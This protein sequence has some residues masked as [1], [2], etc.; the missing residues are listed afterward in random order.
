M[1]TFFDILIFHKNLKLNRSLTSSYK[2]IIK[3]NQIPCNE[4]KQITRFSKRI[5]PAHPMAIWIPFYNTFINFISVREKYWILFFIS[6]NFR[7]EGRHNIGSI[8]IISYLP[9]A[10]SLTLCA[11]FIFRFI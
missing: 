8:Q 10:L 5:L 4:C 1:V 2:L 11:K 9:K 3:T 7:C 6:S